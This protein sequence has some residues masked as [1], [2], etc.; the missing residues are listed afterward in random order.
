MSEFFDRCKFVK[1]YKDTSD[2]YGTDGVK[3]VVDPNSGD[4]YEALLDKTGMGVG[5][6]LNDTTKWKKFG[7]SDDALTTYDSNKTDYKIGNVVYDEATQCF[8]QALVDYPNDLTDRTQWAVLP[9]HKTVEVTDLD[10]LPNYLIDGDTVVYNEPT[11]KESLYF[12]YKNGNLFLD[13]TN[14]RFENFD[15]IAQTKGRGKA[16]PTDLSKWRVDI[17]DTAISNWYMYV[18]NENTQK[19]QILEGNTPSS[20]YLYD[21]DTEVLN[22]GENRVFMLGVAIS[23]IGFYFDKLNT[24]EVKKARS[25]TILDSFL[26]TNPWAATEI[27]NLHFS[28]GAFAEAN[29]GTALGQ[30]VE[31]PNL[32]LKSFTGELDVSGVTDFTKS[33]KYIQAEELPKL[34]NCAPTIAQGMFSNCS[35]LRFLPPDIDFSNTTDFSSF[36]FYCRDLVKA[37]IISMDNA[38]NLNSAFEGCANMAELPYALMQINTVNATMVKTFRLSGIK[39]LNLNSFTYVDSITGAYWKDCSYI[40]QDCFNLKEFIATDNVFIKLAGALEGSSVEQFTLDVG[41]GGGNSVELVSFAEGCKNLKICTITGRLS[42]DIH[43]IFKDC[44]NLRVIEHIDTTGIND[45]SYTTDMFNNCTA[46]QHPDSAEQDA[47]KDINTSGD[48]YSYNIYP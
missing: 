23:K 36:C 2:V 46:L 44:K 41:T 4:I 24:L 22:L 14:E 9:Y 32:R 21:S 11:G 39:S 1:A 10:N 48:N 5:S 34:I 40:A 29:F 26:L 42:Y 6:S 37:D 27:Q 3:L 47:I 15:F 38:T 12:T 8:Y 7:G 35:H 25:I 43:N 13:A 28:E 16:N 20:A 45:N 18:W 31:S 33:F 30:I 19:L 17:A